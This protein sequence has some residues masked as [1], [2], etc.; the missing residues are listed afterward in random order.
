[1]ICLLALFETLVSGRSSVLLI[2]RY[3]SS[4]QPSTPYRSLTFPL[5]T[6][7]LESLDLFSVP[8]NES[9][10][11]DD[12]FLR[13]TELIARHFNSS[14]GAYRDE[15][16]TWTFF[17][18]CA[19]KRLLVLSVTTLRSEFTVHT[20]LIRSSPENEGCSIR[21]SFEFWYGT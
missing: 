9:L 3:L 17:T 10:R 6:S 12:V 2:A 4:T 14:L 18:P 1:M 11:I 15:V 21:A 7:P 5:I 19:S 16:L 20:T 8:F 13:R